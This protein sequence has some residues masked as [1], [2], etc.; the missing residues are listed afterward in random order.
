MSAEMGPS[1][2]GFDPPAPSGRAM[3]LDLLALRN[4]LAVALLALEAL[5]ADPTLGEEQR[6]LAST[7]MARLLRAARRL[8][9]G[10]HPKP[11]D[12]SG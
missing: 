7:G 9:A 12:R 11:F 1:E 4:D 6:R 5:S 8:P 10:A 2:Q 3:E